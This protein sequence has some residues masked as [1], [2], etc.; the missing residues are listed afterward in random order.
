ML[1]HSVHGVS[2]VASSAVM[3]YK[4]S[5]RQLLQKISKI[6]ASKNVHLVNKPADEHEVEREVHAGKHADYRE[7][8]RVHRAA[9]H[10]LHDHRCERVPTK[11]QRKRILN[12]G[13][14]FCNENEVGYER[15]K[16]SPNGVQA[17]EGDHRVHVDVLR[18]GEHECIDVSTGGDLGY[19]HSLTT[20]VR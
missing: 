20:T 17:A 18:E 14:H 5:N 2:D 13:L 10:R 11:Q 15:A 9:R 8:E 12:S 7:H 16:Y 19:I 4:Q 3:E 6:L 1:I